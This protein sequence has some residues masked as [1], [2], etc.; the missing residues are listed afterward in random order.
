MSSWV[1][2]FFGF[3]KKDYVCYSRDDKFDINS[4]IS[5]RVRKFEENINKETN[6]ET[7]QAN[8]ENYWI[9]SELSSARLNINKVLPLIFKSKD[10]VNLSL[11]SKSHSS[12][13]IDEEENEAISDDLNPWNNARYIKI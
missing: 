11:W 10:R 8:S 5:E 1:L 3:V 9:E 6:R 7:N 2:K 4:E 13:I 12:R